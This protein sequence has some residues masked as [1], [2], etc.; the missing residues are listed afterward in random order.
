MAIDP[1]LPGLT[2][3][4]TLVKDMHLAA[5]RRAEGERAALLD[6][7]ATLSERPTAPE[8]LPPSVA[9]EVAL[10]YDRWAELRR[11]EVEAALIQKTTECERL[12]VQAR[13]SVGRDSALMR[14]AG[15]TDR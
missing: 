1:R 6:R 5:L 15:K 9:V 8:D 14:L 4:S 12:K 13:L 10:R 3:I 2:R 11:R 7:I